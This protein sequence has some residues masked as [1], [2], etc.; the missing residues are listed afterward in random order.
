MDLWIE[1]KYSINYFRDNHNS[2]NKD[3][4]N[5]NWEA[6]MMSIG[7]M[8]WKYHKYN[9][10]HETYALTTTNIST[11]TNTTTPA[12]IHTTT[13]TT[14]VPLQQQLQSLQ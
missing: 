7:I 13:V 3:N 8:Q 2:S 9:N 12:T 6:V 4:N 1:W 11:T 5:S 10:Q 14:S